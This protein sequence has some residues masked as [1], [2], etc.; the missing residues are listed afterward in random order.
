MLHV[1][2]FA[3]GIAI[4]GGAPISAESRTDATLSEVDHEQ[5]L[6]LRL[7]LTSFSGM[8]GFG[9]RFEEDKTLS[10]LAVPLRSEGRLFYSPSGNSQRLLRR[11]D[12]P[13]AQDILI[14]EDAIRIREAG[15]EEI[16]DLNARAEVRPLVESL[17]WIFAGDRKALEAAFVV[18]FETNASESAAPSAEG[19]SWRLLLK[20][21]NASL[22]ALVDRLEISGRGLAADRIS[23][24]ES[25]GDRSVMRV[26]D[27][28]PN[29][30]FSEADE[31]SLFG[32]GPTAPVADD[33]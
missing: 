11:V 17:L 4:L 20:P 14:S 3:I 6:D 18:H 21:R 24:F 33:D 28:N 27:A 19:I 15:R 22:K 31:L 8:P 32:S 13:N 26:F 12:S 1:S 29:R 2:F 25:A 5:M 10:L 7:L 30:R 9:A 16:I 23:V